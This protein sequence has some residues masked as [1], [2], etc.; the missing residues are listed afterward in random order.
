[1]ARILKRQN[2]FLVQFTDFFDNNVLLLCKIEN[3]ELLKF[4]MATAETLTRENTQQ[5]W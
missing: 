5:F 1:M 4:Y 3:V 2:E